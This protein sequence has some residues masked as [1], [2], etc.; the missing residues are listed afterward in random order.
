M[1]NTKPTPSD[2]G[3]RRQQ[4]EQKLREHPARAGQPP[5]EVDARALVHEL[6]VHQIELE[7]QNEEM[8]CAQ[9]QAEAALDKYT[10][11]FDFAPLGYFELAEGGV[12]RAANL[13]GA[14]LVGLERSR[15]VPRR[16]GAWV[17]PAGLPVFADFSQAVLASDTKQTCELQLLCEGR[18]A[19]DVRL[20]GLAVSDQTGRERTW[21][22][23]VLDITERKRTEEVLRFLAQCGA[24]PSGE[25]FFRALARYLGQ[26]L[27]MD[28]VCIDR[29]EE[30]SLAARTLAIYFDGKFQ[31]NLSY[32]LKDTPCGEVVGQAVCCFPRNVRQLFPKDPVLQDML[33]ESYVGVTLWGSQ[34]R[35]IGLI[36]ILGRQPLADPGLAASILQLV[37]LRAAAELERR[38]VEAEIRRRA[39]ELAAA[40][41]EL[42]R[43]NE[44]MV[45]RELRMIELKQEVNALCAQLGQPPR[46]EPAPDEESQPAL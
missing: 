6:E 27:S 37:A 7:M 19:R 26:N 40:N 14:A 22:L 13:A 38:Q 18:G 9:A 42:T 39:E 10:D 28:F 24:G 34:G 11:L 8:R 23:A 17:A 1:K 33:A 43:F 45:G 46:Y 12:I 32:T 15:V 3:A 25:D 36:A 4:A 31:D 16:F 30:G 44:A 35:P 41:Q 29:L 20:E 2:A 5:S 21:R